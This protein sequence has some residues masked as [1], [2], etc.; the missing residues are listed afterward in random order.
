MEEPLTS[1]RDGDETLTSPGDPSGSDGWTM[2]AG[3]ASLR[4]S[5]LA[6]G[7]FAVVASLPAPATAASQAV[8]ASP[9]IAASNAASRT[10]R[11]ASAR[12]RNRRC[13]RRSCRRRH[14]PAKQRAP[15][16]APTAL[17]APPPA[18]TT[19]PAPPAG[20]QEPTAL[21]SSQRASA[22]RST[23]SRLSASASRATTFGA[24]D[25]GA[26]ATTLVLYDTSNTW[27]WLGELY[28]MGAG[29]LASHFGAVTAEPVVD[30]QA[31]QV[32]GYTATIYIGSSYGEPIPTAF[33]N[34]ALSTTHPVIWA[35]WNVWQLS[36]AWGSPAD[37]AFQA[38]YGWD[39]SSSWVDSQDNPATVSYKGQAFTR[40]AL[41][42]ASILAPHLTNPA[43]VTVLAQAN[44]GAPGAPVTCGPLAQS[45]G[46]SFPWAIRS[47]NLTYVGEIPFSYM[48]ETDRYVAFS[49]LL[50]A[51]LA[52]S[53]EPSHRAV[54]R[55]EDISPDS[56]PTR[57]RQFA[58]YL[59][60]QKVPF[61][62]NVV[63][64]Y[65]DANGYETGGTPQSITLSQA[66][67][68]VSALKYVQSKGGT[69][70]QH[71]YTHQ[72]SDVANPYNGVTGD[73]AEFFRARCST[74]PS[75]P[76]AFDL[77]CQ[78]SD[79]I[80]WTGPLPG[81]S[82]SWAAGRVE[83]GRK[84]FKQAGLTVPK[85]WTT[86]HYFAS[87]TDY[88]AIDQIVPTARYERGIFF[89]GLLSGQPVDYSH[90]FGQF[91]PYAVNDVYGEKVIPE[92]LGDYEPIAMNNNPPR[93][94]QDIIDNARLNLAVTQGVASFFFHPEA[95]T[96]ASSPCYTGA[97][98]SLAYLKQ[99]VAGIKKLGYTFVAPTNLL[100]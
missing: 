75:P 86:P 70:S 88:Y 85:L 72:Y 10:S 73:D 93:C 1:A 35:G 40:N 60:N 12:A 53:A 9:A 78:S 33:L 38:K 29:N 27:G 46:T 68:M 37:Q 13:H 41:D 95:E 34:D 79:W 15:R 92:N 82:S 81:D 43:A 69:L 44:C 91:F 26:S 30:Y 58:N 4:C 47:A 63:P 74:T 2:R 21:L 77:P 42:G 87:A 71:G 17:P 83:T 64:K 100:G 39:P 66:P 25:A 99:T 16:E 11:P 61:T 3:R 50:F 62:V 18:P 55:L 90:M 22:A 36:G 51:A 6:A 57:L 8:L 76:Y 65:V 67:E 23:A 7:A 5:M 84:L 59:S 28:A 49:D 20:Y 48:S 98:D 56:D 89:S 54:V 19:R 52:P 97:T 80:V 14:T 94:P 32:N 31:G 24:S 96:P 45:S